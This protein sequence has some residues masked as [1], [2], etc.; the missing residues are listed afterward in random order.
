MA[1]I[2]PTRMAV[3]GSHGFDERNI[4]NGS[5]ATPSVNN[6]YVNHNPSANETAISTPSMITAISLEIIDAAG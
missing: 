6:V 5:C 2:D 4:F 3:I 1:A